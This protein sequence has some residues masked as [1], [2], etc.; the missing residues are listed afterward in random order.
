V[1]RLWHRSLSQ[2]CGNASTSRCS[3][4]NC[5]RT[6]TAGSVVFGIYTV[7]FVPTPMIIHSFG[8]NPTALVPLPLTPALLATLSPTCPRPT[9]PSSFPKQPQLLSIRH[10]IQL[11][12]QS[13]AH[14]PIRVM[15]ISPVTVS[16]LLFASYFTQLPATGMPLNETLLTV[17]CTPRIVTLASGFMST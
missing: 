1:Q 7:L 16:T 3:P 2:W 12:S 15:F 6:A 5:Y 4:F 11:N 10:Y 17:F 14:A 8:I 13:A 9:I